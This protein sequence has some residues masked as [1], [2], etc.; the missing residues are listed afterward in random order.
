M[1]LSKRTKKKKE[2]ILV[3][4]EAKAEDD[5]KA[6]GWSFFAIGAALFTI[7]VS[8]NRSF[9]IVGITFVILAIVFYI[10]KPTDNE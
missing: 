6:L 2:D 1:K 8:T 7:G 9:A 5:N 3:D 10:S 4:L